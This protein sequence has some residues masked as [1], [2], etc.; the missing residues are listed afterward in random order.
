MASNLSVITAH[1]SER[2]ESRSFLS[3]SSADN[4]RARL[5]S[6]RGF[7]GEEPFLIILV[8]GF[9]PKYSFGTR[10]TNVTPFPGSPVSFIEIPVIARISVPEKIVSVGLTG[11][12]LKYPLFYLREFHCHC[13]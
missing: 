2:M 12:P 7:V 5:T 4:S 6:L 1:R 10:I 13:L 9:K 3:L 8:H 11:P